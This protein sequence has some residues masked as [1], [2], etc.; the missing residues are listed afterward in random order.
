MTGGG[1]GATGSTTGGGGGKSSDWAAASR[2]ERAT[3]TSAT[4]AKVRMGFPGSAQTGRTSALP[5]QVPGG[6][7]T[8][9]AE[10]SFWGKNAKCSELLKRRGGDQLQ[11]CTLHFAPAH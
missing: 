5:V 7:Q 6:T 2:G 11:P 10:C 3:K 1:G 9:D 8:I 4:S